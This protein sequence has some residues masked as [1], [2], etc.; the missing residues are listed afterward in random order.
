MAQRK[1]YAIKSCFNVLKSFST[2]A[3]KSTKVAAKHHR[4]HSRY[5]AV[6][7]EHECVWRPFLL[8]DESQMKDQIYQMVQMTGIHSTSLAVSNINGFVFKCHC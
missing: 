8:L 2:L 4:I 3:L 1:Q 6:K 5:K 7:S